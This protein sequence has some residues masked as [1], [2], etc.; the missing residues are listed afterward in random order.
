MKT[1]QYIKIEFNKEKESL[2]KSNEN[3]IWN[4]NSR[5]KTIN[6]EEKLITGLDQVEKIILG[7]NDKVEEVA[8]W[9][10]WKIKY[11]LIETEIKYVGILKHYK[12]IKSV[13]L[14]FKLLQPIN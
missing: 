10:K 7:L 1:I 11:K 6:S 12:T 13:N 14:K 8:H 5:S 9:D 2:K 4:E 3:K